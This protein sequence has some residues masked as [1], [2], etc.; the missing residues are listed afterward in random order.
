MKKTLSILLTIV[1]VSLSSAAFAQ[2]PAKGA[3][4]G[5]VQLNFQTG[6]APIGITASALNFRYFFADDMAARL[7]FGVLSSSSKPDGG[8]KVTSSTIIFSPGVE[9][10]FAGTEKLSPYAGAELSISSGKDEY[11]TKTS[12]FGLGIIIGADYYFVPSVYVGGEISYGFSSST[13]TPDG[14]GKSTSSS[15]GLDTNSGIRL[16]I[17]F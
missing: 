9:K 8:E 3:I 2:K 14:G 17:K 10:H 7:K 6:T 11:K 15:L 16:G 12:S 1:A 5:E 4:T 13:T